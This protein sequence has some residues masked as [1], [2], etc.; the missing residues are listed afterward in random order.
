MRLPDRI[1]VSALLSWPA[2]VISA[3]TLA[4][5]IAAITGR[6]GDADITTAAELALTVAV[7]SALPFAAMAV[8]VMLPLGAAADALLRGR[9]S[10]RVTSMVGALLA[11]PAAVSFVVANWAIWGRHESLLAT[12]KRVAARPDAVLPILMTAFVIG[13]IVVSLG[14]RRREPTAPAP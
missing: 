10:A 5:A 11:F 1:W 9:Y 3:A 8:L 2:M 6:T 14:M 12:V 4:W 7:I 13:G